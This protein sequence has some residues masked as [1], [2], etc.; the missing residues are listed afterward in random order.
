[1]RFV[2]AIERFQNAIC[3]NTNGDGAQL[4]NRSITNISRIDGSLIRNMY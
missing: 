1:M 3:A 4:I 2:E